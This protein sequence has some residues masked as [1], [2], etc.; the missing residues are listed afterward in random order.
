MSKAIYRNDLIRGKISQLGYTAQ[1]FADAANLNH[2]TVSRLRE[3]RDVKVSTLVKAAETLRM[4]MDEIFSPLEETAA[5][6]AGTNR[7]L[8]P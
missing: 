1:T 6:V 7:S 4:T 8:Q 3:G 5:P 2:N